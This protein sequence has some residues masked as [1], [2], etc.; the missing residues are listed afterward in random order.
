MPAQP[1]PVLSSWSDAELA[2]LRS[3]LYAALFDYPLTLAQLRQTLAETMMTPTEIL[4]AYEHSAALRSLVEFREGFFYPR[5][6]ADLPGVRRRRE[7]RSR[8]FLRRHRMLLTLV[9]AMP[10]VRAVALSGSI[11]HLNLDEEGDLDLFLVTRRR[12][13]WSVAVA[14]VVLARLMRRRRNVCANFLVDEDSMALDQRDLFTAN[15]I[16]HL[17]TLIGRPLFRRLLDANPFV[18]RFYPNFHPAVGSRFEFGSHPLLGGVKVALE[19]LLLAPSAIVE[20]LCRRAYGAYLM[21]RASAWASPDQVRLDPGCL[22]LHTASHRHEILAR[23]DRAV[24]QAIGEVPT[25]VAGR[26]QGGPVEL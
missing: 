4:T 19:W 22:K 23:F 12:R 1:L 20:R 7:A 17:K 21:R 25:L 6:R 26:S 16:I 13:V 2:I 15:Q 5:G 10:Y 9:C 11:A 8:L 14:V 18:T 3:V 24:E